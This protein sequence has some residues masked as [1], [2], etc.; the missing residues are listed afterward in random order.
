MAVNREDVLSQLFRWLRNYFTIS[1]LEKKEI[2]SLLDIVLEKCENNFKKSDNKYFQR[3]YNPLHS[4]MN[5]ILLYYLSHELYKSN[6]CPGLCDKVYYLN[7]ILHS[8][9]LF[10]AVELPDQFGAEHP[11]GAVMGR[12]QYADGFFFYHGCTVGGTRS[13]EGKAQYPVIEENCHM[14][15]NS[16]I[17]GNCYIGKNVNIGAGALVKNQDIPDNC[18]VFG[19]ST[20]LII[21]YR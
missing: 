5:M 1:E 8:V 19:Q 16:S 20:N 9:D 15:A 3:G 11:L 18:T 21:K 14:Y 17:L 10:Y 13:K 7:K 6:K 12:A 2:D 4:V